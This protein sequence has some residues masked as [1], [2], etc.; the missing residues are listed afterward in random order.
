MVMN[1][2]AKESLLDTYFMERVQIA[3]TNTLWSVTNA[4]RFE[5]IFTALAQNDFVTF[6]EAL[7]DQ[8]HHVNNIQLDLGFTYG[9]EYQQQEYIPNAK[10]GARAPHCW[11]HNGRERTSS[12]DLYSNQFVLVCPPEARH[13]QERY[14]QFPCQVIAIGEHGDYL[15]INHDF[16]ERYDISEGG[17]VLVRPDGHVAWRSRDKSEEMVNLPWL[18]YDKADGRWL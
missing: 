16:L 1:K 8:I 5:K 9:S 17:A 14:R 4:K 13:W 18:L 2:Q 6:T 10:V 12:L 7:N 11:L 3:K 15:P